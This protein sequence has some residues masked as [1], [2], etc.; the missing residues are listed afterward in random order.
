MVHTYFGKEYRYYTV[1]E[2]VL[3]WEND[4]RLVDLIRYFEPKWIVHKEKMDHGNRT[5]QFT[6]NETV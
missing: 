3:T 1:I 2:L 6:I 4:L 5:L